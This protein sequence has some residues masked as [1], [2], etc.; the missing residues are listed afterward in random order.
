MLFPL[1]GIRGSWKKGLL[2]SETEIVNDELR[3][4][5]HTQEQSSQLE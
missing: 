1:G 5:Y 4:S 3:I 2:S